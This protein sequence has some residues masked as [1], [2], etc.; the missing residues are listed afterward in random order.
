MQLTK[1][2]NTL[3]EIERRHACEFIEVE[4][5]DDAGFPLADF[6]VKTEYM[7]SVKRITV[8]FEPK[9]PEFQAMPETCEDCKENCSSECKC[10]CHG[11]EAHDGE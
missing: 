2:I 1:L 11:K 5:R 3:S 9:R 4:A 7:L 8:R 10:W 6:D